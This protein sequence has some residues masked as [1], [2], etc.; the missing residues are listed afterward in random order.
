LP[1]GRGRRFGSNWNRVTN[2]I[3][4][5][6]H[7]ANILT[8]R[9]GLPLN[10]TLASTGTNPATGQSYKFLNLNGGTLRPNLV[11]DPQTGISPEVNRNDFLSSTAFQVQTLN[12]PGDASRDV[13]LSPG[14]ANL[15]LSL[16]K[17]TRITERQSVE[18]R[19]EAFNS[20]N[21]TNFGNPGTTFG[22]SSFGVISS[23]GNPR[24]VQMAIRYRF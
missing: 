3:L 13:A 6:W 1:V 5:G 11:G 14:L 19:F 18:L 21:H 17:N 15:D 16:A 20:L 10:V 22:S 12:T 2:A 7:I 9:T 23:A 24:I 4:G 8:L